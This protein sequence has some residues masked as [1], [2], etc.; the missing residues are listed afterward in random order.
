MM[1]SRGARLTEQIIRCARARKGGARVCG[2]GYLARRLGCS[3][4]QVSRY[5]AE[6]RASGRLEVTPPRRERTGD[7]WRTC[8][9]NSYRLTRRPHPAPHVEN[10]RSTRGDTG[11]TPPLA[12][13]GHTPCAPA[14][15]GRIDPRHAATRLLA[16]L[17][18]P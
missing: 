18:I 11:V 1:L 14:P 9:V 10:R 15:A 13:S 17:G 8:G 6:L 12:G 2:R 16:A 7:G 5:V 4:R 3:T